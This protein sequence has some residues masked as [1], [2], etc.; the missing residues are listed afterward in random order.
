MNR[1]KNNTS[2]LLITLGVMV[3]GTTSLIGQTTVVRLFSDAEELMNKGKYKEAISKYDSIYIIQPANPKL[4]YNRASAYIYQQKYSKALVDLNKSIS[5]DSSY[6]DAYFNRAFVNAFLNNDAF[7]LGDYSIYLNKYPNDKEAL[8]AR[9]KLYMEQKEYPSAIKD[10]KKYLSFN[11]KNHEVYSSIYYAYKELGNKDLAH[12]YID[13]A[14][15]LRPLQSKYNEIKANLL[16]DD[17]KYEKACVYYDKAIKSNFGNI[18][19][20]LSKAEAKYQLGLYND[21]V[22]AINNALKYKPNNAELNYDKAFY[23]LQSKRYK[24]SLTASKRA[25]DLKYADSA[26]LYFLMAVCSNNL[27]LAD[28]ACLYF[29]KSKDLGNTEAAQYLKQVCED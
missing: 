5:L 18:N 9:G 6:Y 23:L 21:A 29:K 1:I 22:V 20:Y 19:L 12:K 26:T 7:A 17:K 8:L 10:F 14:L 25:Y 3:Y 11:S 24:E 13:T 15:M 4:Y 27:G 28:D 2:R 16:F